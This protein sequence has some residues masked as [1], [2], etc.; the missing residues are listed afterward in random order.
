MRAYIREHQSEFIPEGIDPSA[1]A[2]S[3]PEA[4]A[5]DNADAIKYGQ[6]PET[7]EGRKKREQERNQ[8]GLQWAWDTF[9][10]ASQVARQSTT[11]ALELIRDAWE[12]ST[13]TTIL[14]FVIVILVLSNLWT[15]TRVGGKE[16][17][18][19][20]KERKEMR[21][22]EEREKWVQEVVTT[23]W[24]ELA[25]GKGM[26]VPPVAHVPGGAPPAPAHW[27]EEVVSLQKSLDGVEQRVRLIRDSLNAV[28]SLNIVDVD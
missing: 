28:E 12:Q 13:S 5:L 10:G 9:Y 21:K 23:L 19:G 27:R 14:Y 11:G 8:R 16:A 17:V 25:A 3:E 7:E 4:A 2:P 15:L 1:I 6:E 20:R 26:V 18:E 24:D 22:A